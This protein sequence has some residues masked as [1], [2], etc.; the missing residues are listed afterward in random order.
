MMH[1]AGGSYLEICHEPSWRQLF[2]SGGRAAA[3]ISALSDDVTLTT[4]IGKSEQ[5]TLEILSASLNIELVFHTADKTIQ[6]EYYHTLSEP[7]IRPAIPL[8]QKNP[9]IKVEDVNI[10][11]FGFLDGDVIVSG[12]RVVY[13]PQN[14]YEP[15]LFRKN[16][17]TA[18]RLVIVANVGECS[19]LTGLIYDVTEPEIIG[20][21]LLE[22]ENAEAVVIKRG[23]LGATI[24]TPSGSQNIPAFQTSKVWSIGSGDVFAAVFAHFWMEKEFELFESAR[25][26]SLATALYCDTKNLPI[27]KDF[28]TNQPQY[29]AV[30]R[31]NDFPF[32]P[33]QVYLAGPFFTMAQRWIIDQSRRHLFDQRFKVFSPFHDVGHGPAH[34]VVPADIKALEKSDV[35]FAILDGLDAGTLFEIGYARSLNK[36][37]VVFVQNENSEDLKMLEGTDCE[38]VNDFVTAIYK[39]VWAVMKL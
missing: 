15:E 13:D 39:T 28:A 2:G 27:P 4:Y 14:T 8:I 18:E 32:T 9:P 16:G 3:A 10:L 37:V 26:A 25:L 1:V 36:P 24:V 5:A 38:I 23:S 30:Q 20:K 29:P 34:K 12:K 6:F 7:F 17:S 11:R 31:N 35:V 33:K 21:A 19:K 22:M